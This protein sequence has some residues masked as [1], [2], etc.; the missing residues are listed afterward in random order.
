MKDAVF[1]L[2]VCSFAFNLIIEARRRKTYFKIGLLRGYRMG[3]QDAYE[4]KD[5]KTA[6]E[7]EKEGAL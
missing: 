1:Y 5:P 3:Y 2:M 7:L 4:H 6:E